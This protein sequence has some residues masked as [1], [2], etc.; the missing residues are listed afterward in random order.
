MQ[1]KVPPARQ[2]FSPNTTVN[3]KEQGKAKPRTMMLFQDFILRYM[4]CANLHMVVVK[5]Q[6][7]FEAGSS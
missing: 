3:G 1:N 6:C 2:N 5:L 7:Q 4:N